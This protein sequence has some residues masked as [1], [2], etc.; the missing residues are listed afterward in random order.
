MPVS[1]TRDEFLERFA[2]REKLFQIAI[3]HD[4][5]Q[6]DV[7]KLVNAWVDP[8]NKL[9]VVFGELFATLLGESILRAVNLVYQEQ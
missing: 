2:E 3:A 1:L 6:T 7:N 9:H 8:E 4:L 5:E